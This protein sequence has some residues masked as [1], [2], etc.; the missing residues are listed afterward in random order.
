MEERYAAFERMG[1]RHVDFPF[2]QPPLEENKQPS[3][4]LLLVVSITPPHRL[5][6]APNDRDGYRVPLSLLKDWTTEYWNSVDA[7]VSHMPE[8]HR[9]V[10]SFD[11]YGNDSVPLRSLLDFQQSKM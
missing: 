5:L 7:D 9:V 3:H 10:A 8:F 4:S 1:Y 2:V 6:K 11:E